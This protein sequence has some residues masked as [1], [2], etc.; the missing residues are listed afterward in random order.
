MVNVV[1]VVVVDDEAA[2]VR[3]VRRGKNDRPFSSELLIDSGDDGLCI[4]L[5]LRFFGRPLNLGATI[6]PIKNRK[7]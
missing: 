2:V 7:K 4:I 5:C 3:L 6:Y 1:A